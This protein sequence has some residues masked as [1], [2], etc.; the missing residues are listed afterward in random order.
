MNAHAA[1]FDHLPACLARLMDQPRWVGWR[2]VVRKGKRTKPPFQTDGEMAHNDKPE[3][4]ATAAAVM[5]AAPRHNFEGLGLQLLNLRGFAA[6][7]LDK[8]RD[9]RPARSCPGPRRRRAAAPTPR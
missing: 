4:W 3:T 9:P 7:D 6:L 8:V 5:E 1:R 2:W